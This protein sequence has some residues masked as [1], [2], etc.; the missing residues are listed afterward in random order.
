[1][2]CLDSLGRLAFRDF[3]TV[4]VDNASRDGS[5][6]FARSRFPWAKFI[7]IGKNSGFGYAAN[8]A[9]EASL[10]KFLVFLNYDIE[11]DPRWLTELA[12]TFQR[13][14]SI[15]GCGCK[16][17]FRENKSKI[18]CIGGFVCDIYGSGL[19]PIAHAKTDRG[20][21]DAVNEV[22]ALPG[23]CMP[24]TRE[25]FLK[26]GQFDDRYFLMGEDI[27]LSWRVNL[28]G[29]KIAVNPSAIVYHIGKDTYKKGH[30]EKRQI[31]FLVERNTLRTLLKNYSARTLTRVL[32]RF[33]AMITAESLFFILVGR[34]DWTVS[35]FK[36]I[37]WNVWNLSDTMRAR[38]Q[39]QRLRLLDDLAIQ[40]RMTKRN[41]K[42][43][44]LR[45]L[46]H[47]SWR[48]LIQI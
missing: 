40:A 43:E 27:D 46:F 21:Y 26:A 1:M 29:Y 2:K 31:R 45:K 12:K 41:L 30:I 44:L 34:I 9:A 4:V 33:L 39:V 35:D 37:L 7:E 32:P 17:L 25:A 8:V 20:Q 42:V 36:A 28:T 10:G 23:L 6:E 14:S 13:H 19:N 38:G 47:D 5:V 24:L 48:N 22:F 15:G 11:V 16:V 18:D 3:E